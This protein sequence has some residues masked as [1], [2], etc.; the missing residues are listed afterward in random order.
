M[1]PTRS[2]TYVAGHIGGNFF[3]FA[4]FCLP[5]L[6]GVLPQVIPE[7]DFVF[8]LS[9]MIMPPFKFLYPYRYDNHKWSIKQETWAF[10][11][12]SLKQLG[13]FTLF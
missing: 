12:I 6:F 1:T 7:Q 5:E 4:D 10:S 9:F 2:Q 3:C 8:C 11:N 13:K